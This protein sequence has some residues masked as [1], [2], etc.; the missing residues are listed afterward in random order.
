LSAEQSFVDFASLRLLHC[1]FA[2]LLSLAI[3]W[4]G[5]VEF[6]AEARRANPASAG[7]RPGFSATFFEPAR[8]KRQAERLSRTRPQHE[9]DT[10]D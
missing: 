1:R 6:S 4:M 3:D 9:L 5:L 10:G 8:S 7:L 2:E